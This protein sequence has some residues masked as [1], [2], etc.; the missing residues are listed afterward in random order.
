MSVKVPVGDQPK[1]IEQQIRQMVLTCAVHT[2]QNLVIVYRYISKPNTIILAVTAA[3]TDLSTSDAIQ[4]ARQVDATGVRTLGV[5]TK[6]D[7]MVFSSFFI[8][9]LNYV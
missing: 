7:L 5:I 2:S 8:F 4:M 6:L 1:D 3:N 9:T